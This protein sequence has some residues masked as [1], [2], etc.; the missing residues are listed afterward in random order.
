MGDVDVIFLVKV[1]ILMRA[2]VTDDI[3]L[4]VNWLE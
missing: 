1:I 2:C 3:P 4:S